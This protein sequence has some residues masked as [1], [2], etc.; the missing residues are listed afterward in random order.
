[1]LPLLPP[2][3]QPLPAAGATTAA[4]AAATATVVTTDDQGYCRGSAVRA[5]Y[6]GGSGPLERAA[7]LFLCRS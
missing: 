5:F 2:P 4:A 6:F 3:N 1:M 7:I